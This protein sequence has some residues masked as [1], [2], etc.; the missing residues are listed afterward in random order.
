MKKV[1]FDFSLSLARHSDLNVLR[2]ALPGLLKEPLLALL[3]DD[4]EETRGR[5][6]LLVW[7]LYAWRK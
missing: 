4:R 7:H 5:L 3:R 2:A 6:L 1:R